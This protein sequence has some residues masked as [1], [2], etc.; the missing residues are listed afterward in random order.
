MTVFWGVI[1]IGQSPKPAGV[2]GRAEVAMPPNL[3]SETLRRGL[4]TSVIGRRL[5][6]FQQ[7]G[8]TMDRAAEE[9]EAQA[10]EGTVVV[11]EAQTAS[12]GRLGRTWLSSPGNLYCSIVLYP[13]QEELAF[14]SPMAGVALV[15]AI[16]RTCRLEPGLKWPND[17][18]VDG[19]KAAGILVESTVSGDR[20]KH[21]ILGIGV[22]IGMMPEE[23]AALPVAATSLDAET[24]WE[25]P[26]E[27]VLGRLLHELDGLYLQL[28]RG[29]SPLKEW[30]GMLETLGQQVEIAGPDG[31][32]AGLAEKVD[33]QGNLI[34]RLEDGRRVLLTSGDVTLRPA[35]TAATA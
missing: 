5:L 19:K 27:E 3:V 7:L 13:S 26:R 35:G 8:S 29:I 28:K 31:P 1:I 12:R 23:L 33:E 6:F 24:G 34:L 4:Y 2:R 30:S 22:N 14:V 16:R 9:A 21:A 18:M 20:V 15:R 11:A 32:L 17:V 25:T 10:E